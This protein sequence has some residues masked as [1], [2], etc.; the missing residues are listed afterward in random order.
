MIHFN[1]SFLIKSY[2]NSSNIPAK[3]KVDLYNIGNKELF[4]TY[5]KKKVE[6]QKQR[7]PLKNY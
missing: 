3:K 6:L 5:G 7:F 2:L 1:T 4:Y